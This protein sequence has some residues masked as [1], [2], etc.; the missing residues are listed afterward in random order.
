MEKFFPASNLDW[1]FLPEYQ[2][3]PTPSALGG[4]GPGGPDSRMGMQDT[5]QQEQERQ[6]SSCPHGTW[7]T[8]SVLG[9][10]LMLNKCIHSV[11]TLPLYYEVF[12]RSKNTL[13]DTMSTCAHTIQPKDWSLSH[14]YVSWAN[15]SCSPQPEGTPAGAAY[16]SHTSFCTFTTFVSICKNI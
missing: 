11:N 10:Q 2:V 7:R 15:P 4:R 1:P 8:Q 3:L 6:H 5:S 13:A 16:N 14:S 9:T 12:Q